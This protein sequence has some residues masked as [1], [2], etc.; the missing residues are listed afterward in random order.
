MAGS[1][2]R[3]FFT[4]ENKHNKML[5][6]YKLLKEAQTDELKL[7]L[8]YQIVHNEFN[9]VEKELIQEVLENKDISRKLSYRDK[10]DKILSCS[11]PYDE[12][13][14]NFYEKYKNIIQ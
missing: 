13:H 4:V 8:N 11:E 10:L 6:L 7:W 1:E 12:E 5:K 2:V 3:V 9:K 14:Q